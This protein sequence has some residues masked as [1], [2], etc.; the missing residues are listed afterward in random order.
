MAEKALAAERT[1]ELVERFSFYVEEFDR[2]PAF[3]DEQL[4]CH[5]ALVPKGETTR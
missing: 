1:K 4:K 3:T 5:L 2:N